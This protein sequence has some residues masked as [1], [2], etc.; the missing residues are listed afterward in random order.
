[1]GWNESIDGDG[2]IPSHPENPNSY[3]GDIGDEL[4]RPSKRLCVSLHEA[5]VVENVTGTSTPE[6]RISWNV[7]TSDI[8]TN[9]HETNINDVTD[10]EGVMA[11]WLGDRLV[12][13]AA[14]TAK[15]WTHS[16]FDF[17]QDTL[18]SSALPVGATGQTSVISVGA[19][20]PDTMNIQYDC[21][22]GVVSMPEFKALCETDRRR[23]SRL[24]PHQF[25]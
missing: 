24:P 23:L 19:N 21:C 22:F 11:S 25:R 1:M 5:F 17:P 2:A 20:E 10:A 12:Q 13:P 3:Y 6:M 4:E 18:L 8:S 9:L 15:T 7:E 14:D 16:P